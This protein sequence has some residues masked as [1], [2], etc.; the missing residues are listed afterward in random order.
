MYYKSIELSVIIPMYNNSHII[1]NTATTLLNSLR[2]RFGTDEAFEILFVDDGSTDNAQDI[3]LSMHEPEIRVLGYSDNRGKG[4][5]VR[6]GML[7]AR[8][9]Y[10][11]FLDADLAY[12]TDVIPRFI[13]QIKTSGADV[14]IGSRYIKGGANDKYPIT[15]KI[16]SKGCRVLLKLFSGLKISDTQCGCKCFTENSARRLFR[17]C[18]T[19][20]F[21]FDV[22]ILM[23]A[24]RFN[25]TVKEEPVVLLT[26]D[27]SSVKIVKDSVKMFKDIFEIKHRVKTAAER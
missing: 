22:D 12:G 2:Q 1:K 4:Y 24:K 27:R 19:D 13:E 3:L 21:A 18:Q 23:W 20:R 9:K 16:V 26:H 5:A 6:R 7:S 8:G 17:N 11:M 10:R 15:R 14:V 25:M